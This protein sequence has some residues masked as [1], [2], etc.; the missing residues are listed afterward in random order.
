VF[1]PKEIIMKK[2]LRIAFIILT[3]ALAITLIG[4]LLIPIPPLENTQPPKELANPDSLF[5]EVDEI[6]FHYKT[7]GND[8]PTLV[9]LHG[10]G[11]NVYS[12]REVAPTLAENTTVY[13]YDRLAFGLTER[14][15]EWEGQNPYNRSASIEHLVGLLNAWGIDKAILVGNSA[16]GTVAIL[17]A[18]E[19]PERVSALIL[20]SPAV[21]GGEGL[22]SRYGWLINTPQMQRLGPW[23]V[24]EI[25]EW[26]MQMLDDAWHDLDKRPPETVDLYRK[27][28]QVDNWDVALWHYFTATEE[29][30][31]RE[32]LD[33]LTLPILLITGDDDRL[34]PTTST[35]TLAEELPT[36]E[37]VVLPECGHVPQEECPQAFLEAVETFLATL[38]EPQ[39]KKNDGAQNNQP[40]REIL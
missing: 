3:T 9:L 6:T 36:A 2:G 20:V 37:L 17:A 10:F 31:L 5:I 24:R 14:P 15:T 34:V 26:G 7:E 39:R 38:G 28:L 32:R 13:T 21:D 30:G 12:W 1:Y 33:E 22:Y 29:T 40:R 8:Q 11:S 19:Y 4:P 35:I 16:G 23:L 25:Q 18:L 27:P